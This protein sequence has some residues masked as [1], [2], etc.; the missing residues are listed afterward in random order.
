MSPLDKTTISADHAAAETTCVIVTSYHLIIGRKELKSS[1]NV[2][3]HSN[4]AVLAYELKYMLWYHV[5]F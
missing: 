4:G 1:A 5:H 2:S 3:I